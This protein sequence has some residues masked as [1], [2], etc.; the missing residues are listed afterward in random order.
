[1]TRSDPQRFFE[2]GSL[3]F[4]K[5]RVKSTLI[6]YVT[7]MTLVTHIHFFPI[8]EIFYSSFL[9]KTIIQGALSKTFFFYSFKKHAGHAGHAGH[10]RSNAVFMRV[11]F[12]YNAGHFSIYAGHFF[13]AIHVAE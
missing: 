12:C 6:V 1:M 4:R 2:S 8:Q 9:N 10:W 7:H 5:N 13:G 11:T 3:F